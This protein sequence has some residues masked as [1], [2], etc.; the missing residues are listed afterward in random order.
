MN[1]VPS[2][3]LKKSS[4]H[5]HAAGMVCVCLFLT[6]AVKKFE[7]YKSKNSKRSPHPHHPIS[8]H[9]PITQ[10]L[11]TFFIYGS[12]SPHSPY[13]SI[14]GANFRHQIILLKNILVPT[15]KD[16]ASPLKHNHNTIIRAKS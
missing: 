11:A 9:L 6:S 14:F 13:W 16:K 3:L 12:P 1:I 5:T 2:P 10:P 8:T 4:D 7:T 15:L